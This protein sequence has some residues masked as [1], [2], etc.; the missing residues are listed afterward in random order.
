MS[1]PPLK[2]TPRDQYLGSMIDSTT[3]HS[4]PAT[5]LKSKFGASSL[6]PSA[7]LPTSPKAEFVNLVAAAPTAQTASVVSSPSP[8]LPQS[9]VPVTSGNVATP[10]GA[11]VNAGTGSLISGPPTNY[12][13]QYGD[14]FDTYIRSLQPSEAETTAERYLANLML[15][16]KRDQEEALSRGETLGFA[17]GE[18]ARVNRNNQFGIDA[19]ANALNAFQSKRTATSDIAKAK[20]DYLKSIREDNNG[21]SVSPGED[22][23]EYDPTTRTYKKVASGSEKAPN[24]AIRSIGGREKLINEETGDVIKDLGPAS[25]GGGTADERKATSFSKIDELLT[26]TPGDETYVDRNG[27]ITPEGLR[28]LIAAARDAGISRKEFLEEYGGQL[29][30]G[31]NGDY[32]GYGLTAAELKALRGY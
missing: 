10:S 4:T 21:F 7:T 19:A 3:A 11:M 31:D 24:T 29:Y 18:A 28:T 8:V 16:S 13:Q 23:Y 9:T 25:S 30:Q 27:F 5:S 17:S 26:P 32:S 1:M 14:A 20:A 12:D 6:S 15:Q 22:R 2:L